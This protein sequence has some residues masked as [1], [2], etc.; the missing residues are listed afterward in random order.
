MKRRFLVVYD[1]GQGGVWA[2]LSASSA[3]EIRLMYPELEVVR[4][5]PDWMKSGELLRI[6][7]KDSYDLDE[8]ADGLLADIIDRRKQAARGDSASSG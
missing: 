5:R 1:Y 6:K 2:Y 3:S 8:P 7:A 4:E